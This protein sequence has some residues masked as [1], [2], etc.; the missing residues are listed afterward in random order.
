MP[1]EAKLVSQFR[2]NGSDAY[3]QFIDDCLQ[4]TEE[5]VHVDLKELNFDFRVFDSAVELREALREENA[6]NNKSRMAAG[7][8]YDWDVKKGRGD[9]DIILPD[10]FKAKWNLN[11]DIIFAINP[12]S[13]EQVG[14]IHT[15][16]GL[17]FSEF[18]NL[19]YL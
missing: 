7:Y 10:G 14:C 16:Q 15:V 3:I 6:I 8:C 9:Y 5:S 18:F 4:R 2:C 13:F 1:E 11:G 19:I 12:N 17:E